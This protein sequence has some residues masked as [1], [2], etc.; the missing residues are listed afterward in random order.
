M[1]Q[2]QVDEWCWTLARRHYVAVSPTEYAAIP[3]EARGVPHLAIPGLH[4]YLDPYVKAME[5]LDER[6]GT[7]KTAAVSNLQCLPFGPYSERLPTHV[8]EGSASTAPLRF[9]NPNDAVGADGRAFQVDSTVPD[10]SIMRE[11]FFA[12]PGVTAPTDNPL[13]Q[14]QPYVTTFLGAAAL[15]ATFATTLEAAQG[16]APSAS[17]QQAAPKEL[18]RLVRAYVLGPEDAEPDARFAI[19]RDACVVLNAMYPR[20]ARVDE[21]TIHEAFARAYNQKGT[22]NPDRNL[23]WLFAGGTPAERAWCGEATEWFGRFV[24][25]EAG[26]WK[27]LAPLLGLLIERDGSF[28]NSLDDLDAMAE[29]LERAVRGAWYGHSPDRARAPAEPSPLAGVPSATM[30]MPEHVNPVFVGNA[31]KEP[32]VHARGSIVGLMP[33]GWQQLLHTLLGAHRPDVNAA[34]YFRNEGQLAYRASSA[35]DLRTQGGKDRSAKAISCVGVDGDEQAFGTRSEKLVMCRLQRSAWTKNLD[36]VRGLC[37]G[38]APPRSKEARG[39]G[40][41]AAVEFMKTRRLQYSA[42]H[43]HTQQELDASRRFAECVAKA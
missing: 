33:M 19:A 18:L 3:R 42:A 1:E 36:L 24:R 7:S 10:V 27:E 26:A 2:R 16:R 12:R 8:V 38:I 9:R 30:V 32:Y 4:A 6:L 43:T 29:A 14:C 39:K 35:A 11:P 21:P 23:R 31:D 40:C 17:S 13:A 15:L 20:S 5:R 28:D 25:P 34:Q 22:A 41:R 37:L